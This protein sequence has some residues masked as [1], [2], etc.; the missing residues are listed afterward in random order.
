MLLS[1]ANVIVP[2]A[3]VAVPVV[4]VPLINMSPASRRYHI[5]TLVAIPNPAENIVLNGFHTA[6]IEFGAFLLLAMP[7]S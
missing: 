7:L 1:S 4:K 3:P 5:D 2:T 6:S